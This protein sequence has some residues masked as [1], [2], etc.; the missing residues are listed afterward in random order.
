MTSQL[1]VF[2]CGMTA[3]WKN[4]QWL[5]PQELAVEMASVFYERRHQWLKAL[6]GCWQQQ[7]CSGPSECFHSYQVGDYWGLMLAAKLI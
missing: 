6:A 3:L 7:C 1:R 5:Q 4:W 2:L